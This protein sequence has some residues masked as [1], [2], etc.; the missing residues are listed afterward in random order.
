MNRDYQTKTYLLKIIRTIEQKDLFAR[1]KIIIF[2]A[3]VF[4]KLTAIIVVLSGT[5]YFALTKCQHWLYLKLHVTEI[6]ILDF[7]LF[8]GHC[9]YINHRKTK[10]YQ[11]YSDFLLILRSN[12]SKLSM[13]KISLYS[14]EII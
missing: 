14:Y 5:F 10:N 11:M 3:L 6:L 13:H 2:M 1:Y 7:Y 12:S 9:R 4:L 8:I